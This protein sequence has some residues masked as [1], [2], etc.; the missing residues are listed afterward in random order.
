M[1]DFQEHVIKYWPADDD[2][3]TNFVKIKPDNITSGTVIEGLVPGK[4][5]V[6]QPIAK[7]EDGQSIVGD[8][9]QAQVPTDG[10]SYFY[11]Q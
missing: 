10:T 7:T 9:V 11:E 3:Q 6:F 8:T 1:N 4:D 2:S 5:Y